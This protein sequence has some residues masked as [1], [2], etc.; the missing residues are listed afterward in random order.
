[1]LPYSSRTH[2]I[3][4]LM[5]D[6]FCYFHVLLLSFIK[7]LSAV[8]VCLCVYYLSVDSVSSPFSHIHHE[9]ECSPWTKLWRII[10]QD[11]SLLQLSVSF[12]LVCNLATRNHFSISNG[13]L[14]SSKVFGWGPCQMTV[15]NPNELFLSGLTYSCAC[16]H[17]QKAAMNLQNMTSLRSRLLTLPQHT[18]FITLSSIIIFIDLFGT[19]VRLTD[20][21]ISPEAF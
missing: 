10:T 18:M 2:H 8:M 21:Q 14:L 13:C 4:L 19:G 11:S 16:W 20:S 5:G 1:M 9:H 3:K 15:G 6:N 7:S 17:L 12:I